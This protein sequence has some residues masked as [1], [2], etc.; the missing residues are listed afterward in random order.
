M[1]RNLTGK[2]Y[3]EYAG[4]VEDIED[5]IG[6][7]ALTE[8]LA[9][10]SFEKAEHLRTNWQDETTAKWWERVGKL[11]DKTALKLEKVV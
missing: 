6:I 5:K 11:F 2:Q 3:N 8:M 10:I 7:K 1:L 4:T 9:G